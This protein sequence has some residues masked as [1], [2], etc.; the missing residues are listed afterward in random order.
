MDEEDPH[1]DALDEPHAYDEDISAASAASRQGLMF[2][3]TA[4]YLSDGKSN[5][6]LRNPGIRG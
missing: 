2:G 4:N 3:S 6:V 1:E 5:L